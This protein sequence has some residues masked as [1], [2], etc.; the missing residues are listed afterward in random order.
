MRY[1][2]HTV[3][4]NVS[5]NAQSAGG[6]AEVVVD[7]PVAVVVKTV[8]DLRNCSLHGI[9][10]LRHTTHTVLLNMGTNAQSTGSGPESVID[11]SVTIVVKPVAHLW[12]CS[13]HGIAN[14]RHSANTILNCVVADSQAARGATEVVVGGPIAVVIE[15]VADFDNGE[16]SLAT[17][18][19]PA[20]A[21][22][23][24]RITEPGKA[25]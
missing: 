7:H 1:A 11:C 23:G 15:S 13:Q 19:D 12:D 18:D 22:S 5:T 21:G 14:L 16:G 3:L 9:A 25:R 10:C 4:L 24:P 6:A 8:A 20:R 17:L 2:T